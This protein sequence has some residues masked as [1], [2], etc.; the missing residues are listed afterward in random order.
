M[1]W[2]RVQRTSLVPWVDSLTSELWSCL[3]PPE[4]G[5]GQPGRPEAPRS[6]KN[7]CAPTN[8]E[9]FQCVFMFS[10]GKDLLEGRIEGEGERD[11]QASSMPSVEPGVGFDLTTLRS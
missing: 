7:S 8:A 1:C 6:S 5:L 3:G 2:D 4:Q 10:R 11:S 9:V